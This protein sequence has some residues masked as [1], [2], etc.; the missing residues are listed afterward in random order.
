MGVILPQQID[1][2]LKTIHNEFESFNYNNVINT[3]DSLLRN[4]QNLSPQ[5]IIEIYRLKGISQYTISDEEG[6][7]ESFKKIL[8]ID[9][10]YALNSLKTSPKIIAFFNNIKTDFN[11][12]LKEFIKI[13]TDTVYVPKPVPDAKLT[14][15]IKNALIRSV[16]FPGLGHLY[17]NENLKGW[18]LT[19]LTAVTLS[20]VIY[21]VIDSNQKEKEYLDEVD[22]NK[23]PAK[24]N[25]YNSSYKM[26]NISFIS[27]AA[28]WLYA[29]IDLLF[30]SNS[31]T[32][33]VQ[34]SFNNLPQLQYN[35]N[36]GLKLN[37]SI[38]F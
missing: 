1:D 30:I 6:A 16:I 14:F 29:Q 9:S 34:T 22:P 24:Y 31:S 26:K 27:L 10:S 28:V 13:K 19:S 5:Q 35:F 21:Y 37:Y 17:E 12:Q 11:R 33:D 36:K 4:K 32:D 23:I 2:S 8:L 20:S 15:N 18:I 7:K 3:A 38:S 25:E